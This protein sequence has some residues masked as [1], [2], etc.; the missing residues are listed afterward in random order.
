MFLF[1]S[2]SVS[3][4][5]IFLVTDAQAQDKEFRLKDVTD[6]LQCA[7]GEAAQHIGQDKIPAKFSTIKFTITLKQESTKET[8]VKAGLQD[9]LVTLFPTASAEWK[10]THI[11]KQTLA[12]NFS[13]RRN[14]HQANTAAC[15]RISSFDTG[16]VDNIETQLQLVADDKSVVSETNIKSTS[17]VNVTNNVTLAASLGIPIVKLSGSYG[18]I[19]V[20][21]LDIV[22]V[23]P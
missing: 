19:T 20:R 4:L 10:N 23:S 13:F 21:S 1:R 3:M 17:Q 16:L 6:A 9:N 2:I 18:R 5:A 22:A 15:N 12:E 7:A 8:N 14:L 11:Q